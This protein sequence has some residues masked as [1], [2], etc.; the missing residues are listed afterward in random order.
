[1]LIGALP[2]A[3]CIKGSSSCRKHQGL[4]IIHL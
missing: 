2:I 1:M 3:K 4:S